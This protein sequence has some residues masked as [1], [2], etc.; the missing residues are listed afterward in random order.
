[1]FGRLGQIP[2]L[3]TAKGDRVIMIGLDKWFTCSAGVKPPKSQW[4]LCCGWIGVG[5]NTVFSLES[6][7]VLTFQLCP[8]LAAGPSL[9]LVGPEGRI[10]MIARVLHVKTFLQVTNQ[11]SVSFPDRYAF[12][13]I[14]KVMFDFAFLD[15]SEFCL[16]SVSLACA[17]A[18]PTLRS[19]D[20]ASPQAQAVSFP[21]KKPP[22][23]HTWGLGIWACDTCYMVSPWGMTW[24][25]DPQKPWRWAW[26]SLGR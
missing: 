1:M 26:R 21:S 4:L 19:V 7:R 11:A 5:D 16:Q 22:L 20:I 13:V 8:S 24:G 3:V 23:V 25:R 6:D 15:P 10:Q 14:W 12:I 2:E 9:T 17:A 18:S